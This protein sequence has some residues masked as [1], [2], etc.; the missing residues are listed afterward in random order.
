MSEYF[1]GCKERLVS[2]YVRT[3]VFPPMPARKN[4]K[5]LKLKNNAKKVYCILFSDQASP[6]VLFFNNSD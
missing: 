6:L 4:E 5:K 3:I 2:V 1:T